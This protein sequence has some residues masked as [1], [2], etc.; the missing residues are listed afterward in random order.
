MRPTS[1][2]WRAVGGLLMVGAMAAQGIA[3]A[4][5][6]LAYPDIDLRGRLYRAVFAPGPGTL[7]S[8][9][10]ADVPEPLR[11]RL[12]RFLQRRASFKSLYTGAPEDVTGVLRDAKRRALERAIVSLVE[13]DGIGQRALAFVQDAP[14]AD[15]WD[16]MPAEPLAEA[17]YAERVLTM[18]PSTP[19]APFL[20]LF[21][22]QR[23]RAASEAAA[24]RDDPAGAASAAEGAKTHLALA[25]AASDPI[26]G[27]VADDMELMDHVYLAK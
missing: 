21:I 2:G 25:R 8:G 19:L 24:F 27:L 3:S 26:F 16:R 17:A 20:H 4:S 9:D 12:S 10:L 13:A 6:Q 14:I 22:A 15:E 23:Q 5:A 1:G 7:T 11:G 18:D